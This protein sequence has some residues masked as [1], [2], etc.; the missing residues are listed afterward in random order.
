MAFKELSEKQLL[1]MSK[2]EQDKYWQEF[3]A[4]Y[5]EKKKKVQKQEQE[6]KKKEVAKN[7]KKIDHA[8]FLLFGELIKHDG[9]KNFIAKLAE[10]ANNSFSETEKADINLL[11]QARKID[12]KF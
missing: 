7:K 8:T 3:K 9:I 11:L 1:T 4:Y 5:S 6:I 2:E 10:P 12:V